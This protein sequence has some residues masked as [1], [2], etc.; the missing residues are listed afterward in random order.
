MSLL[1]NILVILSGACEHCYQSSTGS[2]NNWISESQFLQLLY[3]VINVLIEELMSQ[4]L[5]ASI[6]L[7]WFSLI[8]PRRS[9][10]YPSIKCSNPNHGVGDDDFA[11]WLSTP[12][13]LQVDGTRRSTGC[14]RLRR[15]MWPLPRVRIRWSLPPRR[16]FE[17]II[18]TYFLHISTLS[19]SILQSLVASRRNI[20]FWAG[21]PET[22]ITDKGKRNVRQIPYRD[23]SGLSNIRARATV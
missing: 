5:G 20:S 15:N 14:L 23:W 7:E 19:W 9:D 12:L 2:L 13:I 22:E 6:C 16:R 10:N 4:C 18:L 21:P 1:K 17:R 8:E 11:S 3:D